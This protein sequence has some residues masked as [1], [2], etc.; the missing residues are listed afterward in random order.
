MAIT[1]YVLND[2]KN[3]L[4]RGV[5]TMARNFEE[6]LGLTRK[7]LRQ[8]SEDLGKATKA[9]NG[10]MLKIKD[11]IVNFKNEL[12]SE[13]NEIRG[14]FGGIELKCEQLSNSINLHAEKNIHNSKILADT[15]DLIRAY[16]SQVTELRSAHKKILDKLAT[17]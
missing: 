4:E 14:D 9:I 2:F 6:Q 3:R 10:D 7:I 11:N 17:L 16:E 5:A 1:G 13:M 8:H 12:F 15:Y